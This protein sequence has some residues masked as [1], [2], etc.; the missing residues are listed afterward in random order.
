MSSVA[1]QTVRDFAAV[2]T[3][4]TVA[5]GSGD[6]PRDR[7]KVQLTAALIDNPP[8]PS[9]GANVNVTVT[10]SVGRLTV[11]NLGG[12]PLTV[13][14]FT[15]TDATNMGYGIPHNLTRD[16]AAEVLSIACSLADHSV[17]FWGAQPLQLSAF[18][19]LGELPTTANVTQT[20]AAT[21]AA[22]GNAL[23]MVE[24]QV[25]VTIGASVNMDETKV[26]DVASRLLQKRI[27]DRV[28]RDRV[29]GNLLQAIE[30]YRDAL[31]SA[32]GLPCFKHLYVALERAVN[33]GRDQKHIKFDAKAHRLT[34]MRKQEIESLRKFNNRLK[35]AL[36][37]RSDV[38]AFQSG[39]SRLGELVRNLKKAADLAILAR[40]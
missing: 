19:E 18:V 23:R 5:A 27:F 17:L 28:A 22:F 8:G 31:K 11:E 12:T 36:R 14:R 16:Q 32:G 24:G 4:N 25:S 13:H 30:N 33:I 34:K 40:I 37:N 1:L 21:V 10:N 39:E 7:L 20:S 35:H 6:A 2:S 38:T 15:V 29:T 9:A 26:I 3:Q